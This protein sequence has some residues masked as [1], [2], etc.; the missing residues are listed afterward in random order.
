MMYRL[1]IFQIAKNDARCLNPGCYIQLDGYTL[2][3]E[4]SA[5]LYPGEQ[6][7]DVAQQ[8]RYLWGD[9]SLEFAAV[10][11][12]SDGEIVEILSTTEK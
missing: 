11:E 10:K 9:S 12:D 8:L 7:E 1:F 5:E 6:L 2:V 4:G 3:S